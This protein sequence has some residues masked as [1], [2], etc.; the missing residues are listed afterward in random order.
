M[1][2]TPEVRSRI[3]RAVRSRDTMPEIKV[4]R[5]VHSMG[6]RFRLHLSELYTAVLD[7]DEDRE[8]VA[9]AKEAIQQLESDSL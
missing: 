8:Q 1:K 6:Y 9:L 4:R 7:G 3:M 5:L 2:E